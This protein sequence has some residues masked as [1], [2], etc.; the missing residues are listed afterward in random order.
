MW[1]RSRFKRQLP[2]NLNPAVIR[3]INNFL[4]KIPFEMRGLVE[5]IL[6]LP[7]SKPVKMPDIETRFRRRVIT[8]LETDLEDL[9]RH[10]GH[11]FHEW[12]V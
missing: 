4:K 6:Y 11:D 3:A 7:F 8:Y 5:K 2:E 9:R 12:H 10:T 1:H